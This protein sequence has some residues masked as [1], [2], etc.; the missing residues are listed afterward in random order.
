MV[1]VTTLCSSPLISLGASFHHPFVY[2]SSSHNLH[3]DMY[4]ESYTQHPKEIC[5]LCH[6][7]SFDIP[8]FSKWHHQPFTQLLKQKICETFLLP[9]TLPFTSHMQSTHNSCQLLK[10]TSTSPTSPCLYFILPCPKTI[11]SSLDFPNHLES[12]LLVL[13]L[14]QS[15][16]IIV[17]IFQLLSITRIKPLQWL[18][19]PCGIKSKLHIKPS[20]FSFS[21]IFSTHPVSLYPH[22]P[23]APWNQEV[24][25]YLKA[26]AFIVLLPGTPYPLL[27]AH[28]WSHP[29]PFQLCHCWKSPLLKAFPNLGFFLPGV[30]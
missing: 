1:S 15:R 2:F 30:N 8:Y 16:L 14:P 9:P 28:S 7:S 25:F 12:P 3:F 10:Y 21:K 26:F 17:N 24:H 20:Y 22:D 4:Y 13:S 18:P 11:V 19:T 29:I 5:D 27:P 23:F 6:K